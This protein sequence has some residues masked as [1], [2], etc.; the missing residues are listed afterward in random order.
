MDEV[1]KQKIVSVFSL[2]DLL[3]LESGANRLSWNVAALHGI[4]EE[5]RPHMIWW[6]RSW[7]GSTWSSSAL[8]SLVLSGSAFHM[9]I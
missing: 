1:P 8:P 9:R 4:S 6:C 7:F 3:T 2:L 5:C